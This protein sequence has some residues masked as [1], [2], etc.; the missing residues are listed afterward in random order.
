[1]TKANRIKQG[2]AT[3]FAVLIT[4]A[5]SATNVPNWVQ[6]ARLAG[7]SLQS[8][9][10]AL[11]IQQKVVKLKNENVSVVEL[12]TSLSK[13]WTDAEFASEVAFINTVALEI[14]NQGMKVV[15]YYP[16]M[17]VVTPDGENKSRS[18]FKDHPEWTQ[19][20]FNGQANVFYGSQEDW[21]GPGDESCWMS[22]NGGYADYF[23]ARCAKL[24]TDT[25]IDGIWV[26]VPL[27]LDTGAPWSDVSPAGQA[28]FTAWS[29]ARGDNNGNGLS[30][31]T[32]VDFNDPL[33]R[34]W[35]QWRHEN[36]ASF[37]DDVRNGMHTLDP[38]FIV[39]IET[40][41]MDYMD[42]VWTGLDPA[43]MGRP[44]NFLRVWE[45]DSVSNAKAMKFSTVEDFSNKIAMFKW[46]RG[47]DRDMPTWSFVYGYEALDTGLTIA[48]SVAAKN[49]PFECQ[50]PVMTK[51][52]DAP[53]RTRWFD[54]IRNNDEAL[55]N[56]DRLARVGMWFSSAT[57]EYRDM[58]DGAEYGMY[59]EQNPPTPDADWWA[60]G[61]NSSLRYAPHLAG[62]RGAAHGLHQLGMTYKVVQT[63]GADAAQIGDV[64][65]L[66]LPSVG[67]LSDAEATLIRNFVSNGG[68]VFATGKTP[69]MYDETGA[70]RSVSVLDDLFGFG[71]NGNPVARMN[72][73]GQGVA[74]YR[75]ELKGA[76]L[77]AGQGGNSGL[78]ARTLG[79]VEQIVRIHTRD[80]LIVNLP[81]G[82]FM[83][84]SKQTTANQQH[85]YIVNY[86]G[87]QQ[88]LIVNLLDLPVQYRAP[89]GFTVTGATVHS[90]DVQG[91]SG[92]VPVAEVA[93]GV[94]ETL[95]RV[96]QFAMITFDLAPE[97][98]V[99]QQ[100][101]IANADNLIAGKNTVRRI[102][103]V[104]LLGNDTDANS[105]ILTVLS[106]DVTS[107][108]G[109]AI[110]L[111]QGD[112]NYV[113][114]NNF[115][116][117]DTFNYTITDTAGATSSAS[118]TVEVMEG[119]GG[120]VGVTLDGDLIDWPANRITVTDPTDIT[121]ANNPLDVREI[122]FANDNSKVYLAY[123]TTTQVTF[124]EG[125]TLHLDTDRNANS[126]FGMWDVGSD[127]LLQGASLFRFAGTNAEHWAWAYIGDL[128]IGANGPTIETS[129]SRNWIGNPAGFDFI[130]YGDNEAYDGGSA[131]AVDYVPNNVANAAGQ[132]PSFY[133]YTL[134]GDTVPPTPPANQA[135]V[136]Q[137]G[138]TTTD[139]GAP[140]NITLLASAPDNTP[141]VFN[142]ATAPMKGALTGT[143]PNLTYT[144]AAS[145]SGSDSFTFTV[146]DGQLN[147]TGTIN[148][149]INAAPDN[150]GG[151]TNS[152]TV[153]ISLD[154]NLSDWGNTPSVG[155]GL[156]VPNSANNLIDL[157][158]LKLTGD[159]NTLYIAYQNESPITLNWGFTL[160]LDTDRNPNT[161]FGMWDAGADFVIQG[162]GLYAYAGTGADWNWTFVATVA[163]V[164][165]GNHA[166]L[167]LPRSTLGNPDKFHY[168]FYGENA[169][170]GGADFEIIPASAM[171]GG[172]S[173]LQ[174]EFAAANNGGSSTSPPA[175]TITLDGDLADWNGIP[176][177][178]Q[179]ADDIT[180]AANKLDILE[181]HLHNDA[182]NFYLAYKND[183]P[184]TLNWGYNLYLD[185]D[186][187]GATGFGLWNVGAEYLVSGGDLF[188][189]TGNG[190]DWSWEWIAPLDKVISGNVLEAKFA[191]SLLG[192]PA[193]TIRT[194]FYGEN[195]AYA[196]GTTVDVAPQNLTEDG[197]GETF[198]PYTVK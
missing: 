114:A 63:P 32:V 97:T 133:S 151:N 1:M 36:L 136:A 10:D 76:D 74:I 193:P 138:S 56:V 55:L 95:V 164:V 47:L 107:A 170:F 122:H 49:A 149:T 15:V 141:L 161:G 72:E 41:P 125:F 16:A 153:S 111:I 184:V 197:T 167:S 92:S 132:G 18:M 12:D 90:P 21:V 156:D 5:A 77:F 102:T 34:T 4:S 175:G 83:D 186:S 22:P 113:P 163:A 79:E 158:A 82:V 101:P 181:I 85:V 67:C 126:G 89:A 81:K 71:G 152:H 143:A 168:M 75:P 145:Q 31:P 157:Q 40:Y 171:T 35:L 52:S 134:S 27:Y 179:D 26:D 130:L 42:T 84:L 98:P 30:V 104:E 9:A 23:K 94:F 105:D 65:L 196:G 135:P 119:A 39:A 43:Y 183:G 188:K 64:S 17:E 115:L 78:A 51:T 108:Q 100:A 73:F 28:A 110:S 142:V 194:A 173:Y 192:N 38:N 128:S 62:W 162:N 159:S 166:E 86:S 106:V 154:G 68:T 148:I 88:P 87:L 13:Y 124:N 2:I 189:Y 53:T 96:D 19:M 45:V 112:Y 59:L 103:P 140:V 117:T 190:S 139:E 54:F 14:H 70:F 116:G 24:V 178:I 185:T 109:A 177:H 146:S 180:G 195:A 61:G 191:K 93:H 20:G 182:D 121:G 46:A 165:S 44:D 198:V 37:I 118:V 48:A 57:R 123:K 131:T 8:D 50:T 176:I 58:A 155:N 147:A 7:L 3:T 172:N 127:Y 160:Y 6:K 187:N 66:W 150:G 80:D 91:T 120:P 144:P 29:A 137:H 174:F 129:F 99:A 69:G 33:F 25:V 60:Q 11:T 169:A